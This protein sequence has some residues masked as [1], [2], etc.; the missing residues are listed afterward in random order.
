MI[1]M[2]KKDKMDRDD[3]E[4][5]MGGPGSNKINRRK[6]FTKGEYG[7]SKELELDLPI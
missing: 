4:D 5:F 2:L 3:F 7:L 6:T 1:K